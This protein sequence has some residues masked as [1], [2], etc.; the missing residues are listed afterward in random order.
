MAVIVASGVMF[1]PGSEDANQGCYCCQNDGN[2]TLAINTA[3]GSLPRKDAIVA[4]VNDAGYSGATNTWSLATITGTAASSPALPTLP[5]NNLLLAEVNVAAGASSISNA[6]IVD[7]RPLLAAAGGIIICNSVTQPNISTV[8]EGQAIWRVDTGELKFKIGGS[9]VTRSWPQT[10]Q[11]TG[12]HAFSF[13]GTGATQSVTFSTPFAAAPK[14]MTNIASGAGVSLGY[15]S[16]AFNI[17]TTGFTLFVY[18]PSATWSAVGC[19][20]AAFT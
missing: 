13:T 7:R 5:N 9:Y 15:D 16:R 3:H 1:V 2:V 18:G 11:L 8:V 4:R 19:Q 6:N 10:Q 14:V 12:S 17:T 20:W